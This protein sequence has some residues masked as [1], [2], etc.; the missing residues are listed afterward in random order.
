MFI[1]LTSLAIMLRPVTMQD[2]RQQSFHF[3]VTMR[4]QCWA[5][6]PKSFVRWNLYVIVG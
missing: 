1:M 3:E 2:T 6:K 4:G 5:F